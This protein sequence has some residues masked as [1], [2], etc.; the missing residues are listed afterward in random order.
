MKPRNRE[1]NIFNLSMLDVISGAL[2][3]FLII[4]II[5][6]PFYKKEPIDYQRNIRELTQQLEAARQRSQAAEKQAEAARALA[7]RNRQALEKAQAEARRNSQTA[8]EAHAEIERSRQAV[9]EAQAQAERNRQRAQEAEHR[10]AKTFLVIYIRWN[11]E[12]Q[13]IDLHVIDPSGAEFYYEK[14]TISGRPGELSEDSKVGPGN[15]VWEI[16]GAPPGK[17]RVYARLYNPH[18]N[19]AVP[20][21][22]GRVIYRDGST[23]LSEVR[24][25]R[26]KEKKQMATIIVQPDGSVQ[27]R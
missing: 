9:Q 18:G 1:I 23:T 10:L 24:L 8:Q 5:L 27:I 2:G 13:D 12:R 3:A 17:Y 6:F 7:E 16:H 4:M 22:K 11:T 15:E 19:S 21:V 26:L 20:T 25:T 14:K